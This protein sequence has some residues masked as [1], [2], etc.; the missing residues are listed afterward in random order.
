MT[1]T[2]LD[3]AALR[4]L[5]ATLIVRMRGGAAWSPDLL[6]QIVS[7]EQAAASSAAGSR[8]AVVS[9]RMADHAEFIRTGRP[10]PGLEGPE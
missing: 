7:E 5:V 2:D 8:D 1:R 3:E 10:L 9:R 4:R 6:A